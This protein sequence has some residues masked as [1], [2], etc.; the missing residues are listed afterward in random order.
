MF[1][2]GAWRLFDSGLKFCHSRGNI[3]GSNFKYF[4]IIDKKIFYRVNQNF[5]P[6]FCSFFI[7][8]QVK[9]QGK[10][11]PNGVKTEHII[12]LFNPIKVSGGSK[13]YAESS[14]ENTEETNFTAF[15]KYDQSVQFK[16]RLAQTWLDIWFTLW[17][18]FFLIMEKYLKLERW[19]LPPAAQM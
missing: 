7:K 14:H 16:H 17:D 3:Q 1:V 13:N 11:M 9:Y 8:W 12:I 19:I 4:C 18:V 15:K 2:L 10:I 5:L 6:W